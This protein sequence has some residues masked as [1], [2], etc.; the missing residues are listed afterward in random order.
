[1]EI[2]TSPEYQGL[3]QNVSP[4]IPQK[5]I[6]KILFFVFL[7][8][9]LVV[10]SVLATIFFTQKT[11][12]TLKIT[13]TEEQK[14]TPTKMPVSE[15]TDIPTIPAAKSNVT[16]TS[17]SIPKDWKTYSDSNYK[18]SISYPPEWTLETN[19]NDVNRD[20]NVVDFFTIKSPE[21]EKEEKIMKSKQPSMEGYPSPC[22]FYRI[23]CEK[24]FSLSLSQFNQNFQSLVSWLKSDYFSNFTQST[25]NGHVLYSVINSSSL[26]GGKE[27]YI[28]NKD[29]SYC[30][31]AFCGETAL[32]GK[33]LTSIEKQFVNSFKFN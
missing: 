13:E 15:V 18:F 26:A 31:L 19:I 22:G 11:T 28:Q 10:S 2:P 9:F 1:M 5:N 7:G 6:Y 12:E 30:S 21:G 8:L 25:I 17:S 20:P 3:D 33:E 23:F 14:T 32:G 29:S 4:S 24:S 16:F 27:F